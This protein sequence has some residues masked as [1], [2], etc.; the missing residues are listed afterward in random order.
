MVDMERQEVTII[1][2]TPFLLFLPRVSSAAHV[3]NFK[4]S[5]TF[6][7]TTTDQKRLKSQSKLVGSFCIHSISLPSA[8]GVAVRQFGLPRSIGSLL[9]PL[10]FAR[11]VHAT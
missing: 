6:D 4:V 3:K 10:V 8:I 1:S 7:S 2:T 11:H 5:W 9:T